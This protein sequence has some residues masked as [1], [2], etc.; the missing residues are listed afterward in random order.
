MEGIQMSSSCLAY[1]NHAFRLPVITSLGPC[2]LPCMTLTPMAA[3]C[4]CEECGPGSSGL[5][6]LVRLFFPSL[7]TPQ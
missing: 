5:R 6:L 1:F 4:I 7:D 2:R 3:L